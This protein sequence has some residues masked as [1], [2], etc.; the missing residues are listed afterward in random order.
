MIQHVSLE[1]RPADVAAELRFWALLGFVGVEPPPP[2]RERS[3][4]LERA[5]TQVHLLHAEDPVAMPQGHVA[6]VAAD[7]GATLAAL[8]QAGF[9]PED[10]EP[11]WGAARAFVRSP[12]GHLVEVM[13]A[14]PPSGSRPG[15]P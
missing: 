11:Y 7:H 6:V 5:G 9:A 8:R 14:P 10:H 1:T 2:L 15:R 12:A 3:T 4:W 13:A